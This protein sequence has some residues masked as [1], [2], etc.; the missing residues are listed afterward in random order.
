M[1]RKVAAQLGNRHADMAIRFAADVY[2]SKVPAF[3]Q[4]DDVRYTAIQE[5]GYLSC[6]QHGPTF[7][8]QAG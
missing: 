5:F 4:V 6:A 2:R 8:E 3:D 1:L 7:R